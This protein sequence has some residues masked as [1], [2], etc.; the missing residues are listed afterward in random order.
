MRPLSWDELGRE[1]IRPSNRQGLRDLADRLG[2]Q[3][4]P[5]SF[6][7]DNRDDSGS[8]HPKHPTR[9][10]TVTTLPMRRVR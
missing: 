4:A 10:V 1:V 7:Y 2:R 8:H 9:L 5:E 6:F 3:P